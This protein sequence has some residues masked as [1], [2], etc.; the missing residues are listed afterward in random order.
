MEINASLINNKLFNF[1]EQSWYDLS[2][3]SEHIMGEYGDYHVVDYYDKDKSYI[4]TDYNGKI[5][6]LTE[7][8]LP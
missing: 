7:E 2:D 1:H 3:M 6:K 4:L 5:V 8:E